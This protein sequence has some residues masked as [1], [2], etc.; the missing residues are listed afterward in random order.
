MIRGRQHSGFTLIEVMVSMAILF[1]VVAYATYML[2]RQSRTYQV[3]DQVTAA[4]QD[5]RAITDL[6]GREL[7]TTGFMV[8]EAAAVCGVDRTNGPDVLV[9]TDTD[10]IDPTN[11]TSNSL[12]VSVQGYTG[13]GNSESLTLGSKGTLDGVPY[14]DDNGDG[15]ADS[16]FLDMPSVGETGGIIVVDRANPDRGSSCGRI[17]SGSLSVGVT[18][19]TVN[20][21]FTF[22]GAAPGGTPLKALGP[23]MNVPDL[24]AVPAHVYEVNNKSQL[25]RDG[26]VLASDVEDMQIAMF[27][28]L[29]GNGVVTGATGPNLPD[30]PFASKTEYPGSDP[31][32]ALYVSSNFD[33][34]LLREI[35][36]DFVVRT[37]SQDPNVVANPNAAQG[38]FVVTEN[39][40]PPG[41]PPDGYR[42]RVQ[43]ITARP[44][45]V[46][47]RQ[48]S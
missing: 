45:N 40:T 47:I 46:G 37:R 22:S 8:P 10:A 35:R 23:G 28:D 44:R 12:G 4:Q 13:T 48:P 17:V 27:Y 9:V 41:N 11:Q 19:A 31:T 1:L 2:V 34:T 21:D 36:V 38:K 15:V 16:D 3:V 42:R 18:T 25:L 30:P 14:Y 32:G 7:R 5:L 24:V 39:R 26:V 6:L 29:D 33:N 43:T 20:V